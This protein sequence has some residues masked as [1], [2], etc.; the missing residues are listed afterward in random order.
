MF[1]S[2]D[3]GPKADTTKPRE[4]TVAAGSIDELNPDTARDPGES[5]SVPFIV[6]LTEKPKFP[7]PPVRVRPIPDVRGLPLRDAVHTLHES[8]FRVNVAA[9]PDGLTSPEAG[10]PLRTGSVVRL[11]QRQ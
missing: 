5:A 4:I 3:S 10:T 6:S 8:G 9:G 1:A 2:R 7:T 11:F